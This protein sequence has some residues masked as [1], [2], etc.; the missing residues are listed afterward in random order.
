MMFVR[1]LEDLPARGGVFDAQT[2]GRS[3][4]FNPH[5]AEDAAPAVAND[6]VRLGLAAG[7]TAGAAIGRCRAAAGSAAAGACRE[8]NV[9]CH[10]FFPRHPENIGR[11]SKRAEPE[12]TNEVR[13]ILGCYDRAER[14]SR[15]VQANQ[16][17]IGLQH[18]R[19]VR[20]I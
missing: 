5:V 18:E 4:A 19:G 16:H 8:S 15:A 2:G 6:H 12:S 1:E 13:S 7:G 3:A 14:G 20:P 11:A 17:C 10:R 9:I